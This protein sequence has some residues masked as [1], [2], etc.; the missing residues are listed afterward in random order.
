MDH[1]E[2]EFIAPALHLPYK[3]NF[4]LTIW[5]KMLLKYCTLRG[6]RG[7]VMGLSDARKYIQQLRKRQNDPFLWPDFLTGLPDKAAILKKLE[8]VY[9]KLGKISVAYVR[10]SNI[11]SYVI[12]YGPNHHA[13]IIQWA[14]AILK[15]SAAR[16]KNGFVG[17][18]STHDFMVMCE[19]RE[20]PKL[21]DEAAD[22]F[23][24]QMRNYYSHKDLKDRTTF[25]FTKEM[26]TDIRIGLMKLV[27]V[28]AD[29]KLSVERGDLI[30]NMAGICDA[31]EGA[32][33]DM[34]VLSQDMICTE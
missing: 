28:I 26:G 9:P 11:R 4:K 6:K 2:N 14:A 30:L 5:A 3:H 22:L 23:E 16:C 17:T 10:I 19:S 12:K 27:Y 31:V 15:T 1:S 29:T 34:M 13:D 21:M 8:D 32:G 7:I 20:M 33:E 25:S 18:L 24:K